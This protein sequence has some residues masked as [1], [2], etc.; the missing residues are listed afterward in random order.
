LGTHYNSY[1]LF[2]VVPLLTI[3][4]S[5][6]GQK[7]WTWTTWFRRPRFYRYGKHL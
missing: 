4:R 2:N 1:R 7:N 5:L 6:K 3:H